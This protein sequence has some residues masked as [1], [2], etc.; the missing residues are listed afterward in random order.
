MPMFSSILTNPMKRGIVIAPAG[1]CGWLS[2]P[3][4]ERLGAASTSTLEVFS[5]VLTGGRLL[6]VGRDRDHQAPEHEGDDHA[7]ERRR[8]QAGDPAAR[9]GCGC[10]AVMLVREGVTLAA[11]QQVAVHR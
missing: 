8:R 6:E 4:V 5:G 9:A 3:Y 1:W 7:D 10:R 11:G 2:R